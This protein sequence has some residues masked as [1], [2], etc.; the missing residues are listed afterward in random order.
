M[1]QRTRPR[2]PSGGDATEPPVYPADMRPDAPPRRYIPLQVR[3]G[4][5]T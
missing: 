4:I 1:R 2:A 3:C 5:R